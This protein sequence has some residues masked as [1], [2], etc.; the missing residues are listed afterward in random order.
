MQKLPICFFP[1]KTVIVD[2]NISFLKSIELHLNNEYSSCKL[3]NNYYEAIDYILKQYPKN[4]WLSNY[5]NIIEEDK[6][7][8]R[9]IDF[10]VRDIC[11]KIYDS[12]RFDT[13]VNLI[14]DYDMPGMNGLEFCKKLSNT[15]IN[16]ILLTG[17]ADEKVAVDAFNKKLI[18]CYIQKHFPDKYES[19]NTALKEGIDNYFEEISSTVIDAINLDETRQSLLSEPVFIDIISKIVK[20]NNIVEYYLIGT[21]GSFLMLDSNGISSTFFIYSEVELELMISIIDGS[22][23]DAN[24]YNSLLNKEL[25]I[26]YHD[27]EKIEL[28]ASNELNKYL[29]QANKIVINNKNYY[30]AYDKNLTSLKKDKITSYNLYNV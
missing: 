28:P 14:V 8:H 2:D 15:K 1:T 16:K 11:N 23:L 30:F 27:L 5:T 29:R 7:Q 26:C 6:F 4:N 22:L 20:Q 21:E 24:I 12:N 13:V 18:N 19:L 25:M 3:F 10:N 9:T 17:V